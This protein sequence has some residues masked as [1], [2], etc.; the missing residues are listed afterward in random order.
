MTLDQTTLLSSNRRKLSTDPK[1]ARVYVLAL[2]RLKGVTAVNVGG[3][4]SPKSAN[5]AREDSDWDFHV[6]TANPRKL[7]PPKQWGLNGEAHCF[8]TSR[9]KDVEVWPTDKHGLL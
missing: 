9:K 6:I 3:S 4:R 5:I 8:P 1:L 7:P 2:S